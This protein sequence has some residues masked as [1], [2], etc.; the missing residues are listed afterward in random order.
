M[1]ITGCGKRFVWLLVVMLLSTT[2]LAANEAYQ[3][4]KQNIESGRIDLALEQLR[5]EVKRQSDSYQAWFLLGVAY[6]RSQQFHQAMESFRRVIKINPKLAEPHNNLAVIY[7][8]LG[9]YRAAVDELETS[10]VKKPGD[11]V[12]EENLADLYLKLALERYRSSLKRAPNPEVEQRYMRLLKVRDPQSS[13]EEHIVVT[14]PVVKTEPVKKE[15]A[16]VQTE[17]VA[18]AE[19][20]VVVDQIDVETELRKAVEAW[21]S[22][23]SRRDLSGYF[24][25]YANDFKVPK[26]FASR[27]LWRQYKRQVIDLK[28][29]IQVELTD[30]KIV[31][32][33][34]GERATIDFF[35]K[36]RSNSYN[37]DSSKRLVMK[38]HNNEWK[39]VSED[40]V[41]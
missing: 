9:D 8:E 5:R 28:S 37:G 23:W 41:S 35:Q 26:R 12:A 24:L 6:T 3:Q 31:V 29:Y 18:E 17:V 27:E 30:L 1:K 14:I 15:V 33:P 16:V 13:S 11:P 21:R 22:A 19:V 20:P 7:N 34:S 25:M 36:F 32:D 4:V 40:S 2:P 10:L 38:L 39:I